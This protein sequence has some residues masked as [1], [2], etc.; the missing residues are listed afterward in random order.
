MKLSDD[1]RKEYMKAG[2]LNDKQIA[3]ALGTINVPETGAKA[4]AVAAAEDGV[5]ELLVDLMVISARYNEAAR[6][7]KKDAREIIPADELA[8]DREV[9]EAMIGPEYHLANPFGKSEGRD[10]TINKF[11]SGT[12]RPDAFG[13]AGF[14][15]S[16]HTLQVH[17]DD[18]NPH[19]AVSHGRL[20]FKGKGAVEYKESGRVRWL[21]LTGEYRT[22][23]T[24]IYRDGR[25]QITASQM[26]KIPD[27]AAF[28]FVGEK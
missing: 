18:G 8:R 21:D 24:F 16:E 5:R 14:K 28:N 9:L 15:S 13:Q 25:W 23:H 1:L 10:E 27:K 7:S 26:T 17:A 4:T 3:D 22:T 20:K 19:T 6:A 12:I 11:L 2:K